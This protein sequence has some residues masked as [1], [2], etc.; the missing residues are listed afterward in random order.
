MSGGIDDCGKF[1]D[2]PAFAN[3]YVFASPEDIEVKMNTLVSSFEESLVSPY[4]YAVRVAVQL[5]LDFVTIHPF[6]NWNGRM[7]RLLFSYALQR[8]GF[9]FPV[10]LDSGFK[11]RTSTISR[12]W[13]RHRHVTKLVP[14]Y[15]LLCSPSKRLWLTM[16]LSAKILSFWDSCHP[17]RNDT[18]RYCYG[19]ALDCHLLFCLG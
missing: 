2:N 16:G 13:S 11:N 10:T 1:R 5:M 19:Y 8:M 12:H 18:S 6:R 9:S 15:N 3:D 14:F 7:C 17:R 4:S